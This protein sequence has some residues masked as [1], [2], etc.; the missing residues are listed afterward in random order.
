MLSR[1][2]PVWTGSDSLKPERYQHT[3]RQL[4]KPESNPSET[5]PLRYSNQATRGQNKPVP[6]NRID[7]EFSQ[8]GKTYLLP[9][10][11]DYAPPE[12]AEPKEAAN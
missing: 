6:M 8:W 12:E 1:D 11:D 2:L 3:L 10:P 9:F 4:A 7:K 5:R